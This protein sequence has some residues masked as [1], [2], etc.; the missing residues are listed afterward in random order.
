MKHFRAELL[1]TGVIIGTAAFIPMFGKLER[2]ESVLPSTTAEVSKTDDQP[3][4]RDQFVDMV[5]IHEDRF[6]MGASD[7]NTK[8]LDNERPEHIVWLSSYWIDKTEVTNK[9]FSACVTAGYC[10]AP[11]DGS[12]ETRLEYFGNE[13]YNDYPVIHVDW[14]QASYYCSFVGKRLPTEAEWE[15]AAR[16]TDGLV[17]PWGNTILDPVPANIDQFQKGDTM[18]VGSFPEGASPYGVLDM[19]GNVWEWV[20]DPYVKEFYQ[21]S[22]ESDPLAVKSTA[23]MVIRGMSWAYPFSYQG[24][25]LR[26]YTNSLQ[27]TND[28]GFR[29]AMDADS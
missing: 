5:Y 9:Q 19:E 29:C 17:Y 7:D 3:R 2:S 24:I 8:A 10:T 23:D 27:H 20:Q 13:L 25:T 18:P 22:P 11:R 28:L 15:R 14:Y 6:L 12:S 1:L 26:N 16:G 21:S 4:G